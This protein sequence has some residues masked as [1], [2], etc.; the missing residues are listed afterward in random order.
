ML[1]KTGRLDCIFSEPVPDFLNSGFQPLSAVN[2]L[3]IH[4]ESDLFRLV[5]GTE[6]DCPDGDTADRMLPTVIPLE[7]PVGFSGDDGCTV[8]PHWE[9]T[10]PLFSGD[11]LVL[12]ISDIY[13]IHLMP[14]LVS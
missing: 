3:G 6:V 10:L 2:F 1:A 12:N 14:K 13:Q 4:K 8:R 5:L 11:L 9:L 7:Q